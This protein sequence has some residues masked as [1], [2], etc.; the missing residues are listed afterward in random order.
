[1]KELEPKLQQLVEQGLGEE[2][3][4]AMSHK[5]EE[6]D[7]KQLELQALLQEGHKDNP[8]EAVMPFGGAETQ[9]YYDKGAAK[10][11]AANKVLTDR[12]TCS[13][14]LRGSAC[15]L[16]SC[17]NCRCVY[18]CNKKCQAA[19]WPAHKLECATFAAEGRRSKQKKGA[20]PLTW[21]Q[22]Q[23]FGCETAY[24]KVLE[25]R[26]VVDESLF[27]PVFGCK[28]RTGDMN[29]IAVYTHSAVLNGLET[30]KVLRW[31]NPRFHYFMDGRCG[32]RIE[33]EDVP[34]VTISTN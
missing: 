3:S 17:G 30:G 13:H 22:L 26:V 32:A 18:Y 33:D 2:I 24:G 10:P 8:G 1:M 4:R 25:V 20:Q 14:C 12:R 34:N 16:K 19:A 31:K 15:S 9:Q 23:A 29:T 27:R 28:D 5:Q 21:E 6:P 11:P 7:N